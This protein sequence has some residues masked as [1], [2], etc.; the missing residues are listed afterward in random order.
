MTV[1]TLW[2]I[3]Q[4]IFECKKSAPGEADVKVHFQREN[5]KKDWRDR[6]I[7]FFLQK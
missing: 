1:K 4:R 7:D 6:L 3:I 2:I 5:K